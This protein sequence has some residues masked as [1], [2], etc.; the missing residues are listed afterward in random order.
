MDHNENRLIAED[1]SY[2]MIYMRGGKGTV[3]GTYQVTIS[4]IPGGSLAS[5]VPAGGSVAAPQPVAAENRPN[6]PPQT[7]TGRFAENHS[8]ISPV[9]VPVEGGAIDFQLST[10]M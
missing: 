10:G 1:G 8:T 7:L 5:P 4:I 2:E 6:S 3:A 9:E